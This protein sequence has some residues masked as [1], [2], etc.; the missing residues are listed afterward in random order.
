VFAVG[1]AVAAL[2]PGGG[3]VT[4]KDFTDFYDSDG[5][6]AT[7]FVLF[8]VLVVGSLLMIWFFTELTKR[9][10]DDAVK[11]VAHPIAIVAAGLV[12]AGA[13]ILG[14]PLGVQMSS[15]SDFVGVPIAHTFA[16]A[17][18][19][20]MLA[21]GMWFFAVA[22]F[23]FSLS[24]R[25]SNAFPSWLSMAGMVVGVLLLGSYIWL[26]GYLLPIWVIVV[27]MTAFK[28]GSSTA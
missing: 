27:A 13:A 11:S 9:L 15:D 23:L 24:A 7:A 10:P 2:I 5:K 28:E 1:Y 22:V 19:A 20:V 14:G 26:P 16:Q 4:D 17:G 8:V 6:R 3:D 25:R 12:L 18:F 21:G